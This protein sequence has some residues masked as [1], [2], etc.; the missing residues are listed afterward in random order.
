MAGWTGWNWGVYVFECLLHWNVGFYS[1]VGTFLYSTFHHTN[2]IGTITTYK[3][4]PFFYYY[5]FSLTEF[6]NPPF[7]ITKKNKRLQ[8]HQNHT[9]LAH[10]VSKGR[11]NI[12]TINNPNVPKE[13]IPRTFSSLL[14]CSSTPCSR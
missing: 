8:S 10:N 14:L 12:H 3:I 13:Y 5:Y 4:R 11:W 7:S 1:V 9:M 2:Y 6:K